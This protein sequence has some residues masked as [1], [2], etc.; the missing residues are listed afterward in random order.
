[1]KSFRTIIL[2]NIQKLKNAFQLNLIV[3]SSPFILSIAGFYFSYQ[4]IVNIDNKDR[5]FSNSEEKT[6]AKKLAPVLKYK[7]IEKTYSKS[8]IE[9][10]IIFNLYSS[11]IKELNLHLVP[12]VFVFESDNCF[13]HVLANGSL[14]IS[15]QFFYTIK[16]QQDFDLLTYV[17]LY[18]T[19]NTKMHNATSELVK[20]YSKVR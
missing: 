9:Y 10:Q 7:L 18:A 15:D 8:S 3:K 16:D 6:I 1:M 14:F 12:E 17:I 11:I 2:E 19:L 20:L 4:Y 13:L 5:V